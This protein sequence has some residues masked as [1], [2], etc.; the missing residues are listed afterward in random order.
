[1]VGTACRHS[2][3]ETSRLPTGRC[4]K[5]YLE[6]RK[7][8]LEAAHV[9]ATAA[10]NISSSRARQPA[11]GCAQ[12][13]DMNAQK[14]SAKICCRQECWGIIP[15]AAVLLYACRAREGLKPRLLHRR[16]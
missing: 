2:K 5:L 13:T 15:A 12:I 9:S 3:A 6:E 7:E 10:G 1:M 11:M 8:I 4:W 16:P 14:I